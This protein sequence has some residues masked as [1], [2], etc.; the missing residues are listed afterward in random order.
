MSVIPRPAAIQRPVSKVVGGISFVD[1]FDWLQADSDEA[2]AWQAEQDALAQAA[3][4]DWPHFERLRQ[5]I[6]SNLT[7]RLD[8]Y[9]R[10]RVL[11]GKH[12]WLNRSHDDTEWEVRVASAIGEPGQTIV[13]SSELADDDRREA[14]IL[15]IEPSP[16]GLLCLLGVT[17]AGEQMGS[18]WVVD[19]RTGRA[20]PTRASNLFLANCAQPGWL[21]DASAFLVQDRD[22]QG[23]MVVHYVPLD[24]G[25]PV[26]TEA[27][28]VG[29]VPVLAPALTMQVSPSGR[30]T[31]GLTEPHRRSAVLL[32]DN[33]SGEWR[34]FG[35]LGLGGECHGE[36]LNDD[37]YAAI[38]THD[39][40]LGRIVAIPLATSTDA[41]TWRELV[42]QSDRNLRTLTV[43]GG[44]LVSME[45]ADASLEVHVYA[46]DG[47][48][49]TEVPLPPFG[50][51][52]LALVP[53]RFERTEALLVPYMSFVQ[54]QTWYHFAFGGQQL[55]VVGEPGRT[56][57]GLDVRRHFATR[58]DGTRVPYFT[59][60]EQ[61]SAPSGPRPALINAYG[62]FGVSWLPMPL[63]HV[64]SFVRSGGVYVHACL[65]GGGE[66]GQR[67]IDS[68]RLD[69]LQ[70]TY[71]DLYAVAEDVV[72]RG[73][74][75]PG[76]LAF[77]GHSQ[78]GLL[79]G[80]VAVQRPDLWAV[81]CPTSPLLDLMEP[82]AKSPA[83]AA[84][85]AY[86]DQQ[87]GDSANP[88]DAAWLWPVSPYHNLKPGVAYPAIYAVFGE[89]DLG[90]APFHG[91]KFVARLRALNAGNAPSHLRVHKNQGHGP[92]GL[93]DAAEYAAEWLGFVMAYMGMSLPATDYRESE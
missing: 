18:W 69:K 34:P 92:T 52:V 12:F 17:F 16:D 14:S 1:E 32:R 2:L 89:H 26:K 73:T 56:S 38:T 82:L 61:R 53:R 62:G 39:A 7:A 88:T 46:A 27:L 4:R 11:G 37:E 93:G 79:A 9:A 85:K 15:F 63:E 31:V 65:R 35:P 68:G 64:L 57:L 60:V 90:C 19:V 22:S 55:A 67:W 84:I 21:P 80:V 47:K 78:G 51:S 29:V 59:V 44:K 76:A 13:R 58:E 8:G 33:L 50:C 86:F 70:N 74:A 3:A 41:S 48:H 45:L 87:Y 25:L 24:E 54:E 28:P 40:D 30:W 91:R 36:W 23:A 66:Y 42:P 43:I 49:E 20:V 5:E 10:H 71:D 6:A 72:S 77:Q 81:V 83:S 75:Q